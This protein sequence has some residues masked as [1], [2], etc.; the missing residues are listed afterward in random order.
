MAISE[1]AEAPDEARRPQSRQGHGNMPSR[2]AIGIATSTG[3]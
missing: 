1:P 2:S 3:T